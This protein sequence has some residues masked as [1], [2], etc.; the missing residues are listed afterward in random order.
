MAKPT[1]AVALESASRA[2]I[3]LAATLLSG[4][5]A[6]GTDFVLDGG[7]GTA[8]T[9]GGPIQTVQGVTGG[10]PQPVVSS[11][12]LTNRSSTITTGGTA[13]AAMAANTSRKYVFLRNPDT[14][15]EDLWFSFDATAVAAAP[16]LVLHAGDYWE[17]D[18]FVPTGALSVIAATTAHAFTCKEG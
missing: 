13:Q 4:K 10:T 14:A 1:R 9:P 16:S 3:E 2:L 8:G 5:N 12:A 6:D 17:S 15:T 7:T 18:F 11:G